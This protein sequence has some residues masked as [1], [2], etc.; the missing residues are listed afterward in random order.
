MK[1]LFAGPC[2]LVLLSL[3]FVNAPIQAQTAD[4][5]EGTFRYDVSHEVILSGTVAS[6]L[7]KRTPGMIMGS[8]LLLTTAS[9]LVDASLGV[10]GLRGKGALAVTP[11]KQVEVTGVMKTIRNKQVFLARTVTTDGKTYAIRNAY[12]IPVSP[13][14]RA[15]ASRKSAGE[16]L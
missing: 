6:V 3:F 9:G 7:T 15:R 13:Q 1:R 8:H 11:G 12:G 2:A 10:F 14:A 16:G 4:R 5:S